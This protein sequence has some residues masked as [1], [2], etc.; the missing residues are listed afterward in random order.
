MSATRHARNMPLLS[1]RLHRCVPV[2]HVSHSCHIGRRHLTARAITFAGYGAP[3]SVLSVHEHTL[4]EPGSGEFWVRFLASPIN[5]ADL[6]QI[7]GV[8]PT[9]P[10][11]QD[12]E[13]GLPASGGGDAA[14]S[15]GAGAGAGGAGGEGGRLA[16]GGNEGL[17]E[18]IK[19]GK[20]NLDMKW[21]LG[22]WCIMR[23]PGFG[24]WRS[25]AVAR[26]D[27]LIRLSDVMARNTSS[28][29]GGAGAG[30]K[31]FHPVGSSG[32]SANGG[33]ASFGL[34][35]VQ[36][37]QVGVNPCTAYRMLL[38]FS[39]LGS[40]DWWIQNGATSA[41]GRCAIQLSKLWRY[42]SINVVREKDGWESTADELKQLGADVVI[43]D[44][45]LADRDFM[46]P[47]I[48]NTWRH[49]STGRG[50]SLALNCVGGSGGTHLVKPLC[51]G[52]HHVTYGAMA[53]QPLRIAA[54]P[55]IFRDIHFH[56]FWVSR[57]ADKN[58]EG[59]TDMLRD[60]LTLT[61]DRKFEAPRPKLHWWDVAGQSKEQSLEVFRQALKDSATGKQMLCFA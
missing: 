16:V 43:T 41:V 46:K 31:V 38:D 19:A 22:E 57:W 53:R 21:S 52:G 17:C 54:S 23:R 14:S 36:V 3:E 24:T 8:Y 56:G 58:P 50:V 26:A 10:R 27:D 61:R 18:I 12:T 4:R 13:L 30:G 29:S 45:Q 34:D 5:P 59:K 15:T 47:L 55:L 7:E 42:K 25:H 35:P 20:D 48:K 6:N 40:G 1:P 9:R 49:A 44:A 2:R 37:A 28:K 33:D 11:W 60:I 39:T 32:S 51:E